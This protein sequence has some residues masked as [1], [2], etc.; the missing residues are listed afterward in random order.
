[1]Q[2]FASWM[3]LF[4]MSLFTC[5]PSHGQSSVSITGELNLAVIRYEAAAPSSSDVTTLRLDSYTTRIAVKGKEDLGGNLA[6]DFLIGTGIR[7]DQG[8]GKGFCNRECW[9]RLKGAWGGV[10]L[11]RTLPIYDDIS[12][13]WYFIDSPGIHNPLSLWANCGNGADLTSGCFD[14]YQSGSIRYDSPTRAGFAGS[15][16][17]SIPTA[18]LPAGRMGRVLVLGGTYTNG[19]LNFG[20]AHQVDRHMRDGGFVD[21]ATTIAASYDGPIYI[22]GGFEHL[23][24]GAPLGTRLWRNYA[25]GLVKFEQGRN[26]YWANYGESFTGQGSAPIG[27][28]VNA[29]KKIEHSGA[30]MWTLGYRYELSKRTNVSVFYNELSNDRNGTYSFDPQLTPYEGVGG[31]MSGLAVGYQKRF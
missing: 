15:F 12:Y 20:V 25:G 8:T 2:R 10:K 1:M 16:S 29:V 9:V 13:S 23:V 5:L 30:R 28:T 4:A 6:A 21:H 22:G 17:Y 3:F 26:T 11:G 19:P 27:Y 24:Y 14:V 18:E 7:A 31:Q